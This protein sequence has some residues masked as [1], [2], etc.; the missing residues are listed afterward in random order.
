MARKYYKRNFVDAVEI[1]T[2]DLYLEDDLALS[3]V[4][5]KATDQLINS[6]VISAAKIQETLKIS[7]SALTGSNLFSSIDNINGFSQFFLTKN[8]LTNVTPES[9]Q[10]KILTPLGQKLSSFQSSSDFGDYVSG[11]F[12]PKIY[13]NNT[14]IKTD[15][16]SYFGST[17]LAT[18]EYIINNLGWLYFLNTS[19]PAGGSLAP[20]TL[21][22]S[23]LV[24]TIYNDRDYKLNDAVKDY[25]TYIW[26]NYS[27]SSV[28]FELIPNRFAIG[29]GTFTSGT[30]NLEKLKTLVD[31]V[32]SPLGIDKTD[33]KIEE[34]FNHYLSATEVV[35]TTEYRGPFS[36]FLRGVSYGMFDVNDQVEGLSNLNSIEN[37]PASHL[38]FLADILGWK[39]YGKNSASWRNQIRNAP[40]IYSKKGTKQAIIDALNAIIPQNPINTSGAI[41]E[42]YESYLPNLIYYVLATGTELFDPTTFTQDIALAHGL[43]TYSQTNK[44]FNIR[45]GVDSVLKQLITHFPDNFVVRNQPFRVTRLVNGKAW[46][47]PIIEIA[48]DVWVTAIYGEQGEILYDPRVAVDVD[49]LQDPRF[50]FNYRN[51]TTPMPPWEEE[52]F[53]DNCVVNTELLLFLSQILKTFGVSDDLVEAL[54]SYVDGYVVRASYQTD[55]YIGN[56][57]VFYTSGQHYPPN[58]GSIFANYEDDKYEYLSLW[59]GKSSTFDFSVSGGSFDDDVFQDSSAAVT[60]TDILNSLQVVDDLSPAKAIPR[61]R[62]S[63]GAAESASGAD[64]ICASV[65]VGLESRDPSGNIGG[66]TISGVYD[67]AQHGSLGSELLPDFVEDLSRTRFSHGGRPVF[68]REQANYRIGQSLMDTSNVFNTEKL[69]PVASSVGRNSARRRNFHNAL[70]K[71]KWFS[72]GGSNMPCFYNNTGTLLDFVSLGF[73]PSAFSFATPS[74]ETL[75][76]V[77]TTDCSANIANST[78]T[79]FGV[80]TKNTFLARSAPGGAVEYGSC[81]M[82]VRRDRIPEEILLLYTLNEKKKKA[83]AKHIYDLNYAY[84]SP[85]AGWVNMVDSFANKLTDEGLS[86]FSSPVF[87]QRSL[88]TKGLTSLYNTYC[89]YFSGTDN[90]ALPESISKDYVN[91]GANILSHTYGPTLRNATFVYDGSSLQ[92][93]AQLVNNT[94]V[95]PFVINLALSSSTAATIGL[96]TVDSESALNFET[97]EYRSKNIL[98]GIDF[99]DTSTTLPNPTNEFVIFD[100]NNR[101]SR[102]TSYLENNRTVLLRSRSHGLPRLRWGLRSNDEKNIL[103]PESEYELDVNY[104]TG[105]DASPVFGGGS[106]GVMIHTKKETT[107]DGSGV[108]FVW[109]KENKWE[110]VYIENLQK[111]GAKSLILAKYVHFFSDSTNQEDNVLSE[112]GDDETLLGLQAV[113]EESFSTAKL[114]FHTKNHLTLPPAPYGTNFIAS[115]SSVFNGRNVQVH[116]GYP[117]NG[118]KTQNYFVNIMQH[119]G[120]NYLSD[121]F[122]LVDSISLVNKTL[123]ESAGMP[124]SAQIP[125]SSQ[126]QK[127]FGRVTVLRSDG[128]ELMPLDIFDDDGNTISDFASTPNLIRNSAQATVFPAGFYRTTY[129]PE[130]FR[131][132]MLPA[133]FATHGGLMMKRSYPY[134]GVTNEWF[135]NG[136]KGYPWFA[137]DANG[138][139]SLDPTQY[140]MGLMHYFRDRSA[141]PSIGQSGGLGVRPSSNP[142]NTEGYATLGSVNRWCDSIFDDDQI[143]NGNQFGPLR[144]DALEDKLGLLHPIRPANARLGTTNIDTYLTLS[145]PDQLKNPLGYSIAQDKNYPS[146]GMN[147]TLLPIGS[148]TQMLFYSRR[149][150]DAFGPEVHQEDRFLDIIENPLGKIDMSTYINNF[151]K[152]KLQ[153]IL[154][155]NN[156]NNNLTLEQFNSAYPSLNRTFDFNRHRPCPGFLYQDIPTA[157]LRNET[158]YSFTI[159]IAKPQTIFQMNSTV[160]NNSQFLDHATSAM[161]TLAPVDSSSSYVRLN[162]NLET[163]ASSIQKG[164]EATGLA[165][166]IAATCDKTTSYV[167]GDTLTWYRLKVTIPYSTTE[168]SDT[169]ELDNNLWDQAFNTAR[170]QFN[171]G[172]RCSVFA[173]NGAYDNTLNSNGNSYTIGPDSVGFDLAARVLLWGGSLVEGSEPAEWSRKTGDFEVG[174]T[175]LPLF[176]Y[177]ASGNYIANDGTQGGDPSITSRRIF[178]DDDGELSY[179]SEETNKLEKLTIAYPSP[180][181]NYMQTTLITQPKLLDNKGIVHKGAIYYDGGKR[182]ER[183]DVY[184][185][186]GEEVNAYNG[187]VVDGGGTGTFIT[188]LIESKLELEPKELLH[189]FRYFNS[190][191]QKKRGEAFL[192]RV[193]SDSSEIHSVSGGSRV[194]YRTHPDNTFVGTSGST[195]GNFTN[196]NVSG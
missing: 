47:G 134:A 32:Y 79:R 116:R 98:S 180:D 67:R 152:L 176:Y 102:Q 128:E 173:Y 169:Y 58:Q 166:S 184:L 175:T 150:H 40:S 59:S 117:N 120:S 56:S 74:T 53:Y 9:F 20:S 51:K 22:A 10:E 122:L 94:L 21:V 187:L 7:A 64:Y 96:N 84:L 119:P 26:E 12:L 5:V 110:M 146:D 179:V 170:R 133:W 49:I 101:S 137:V 73:N 139:P 82:Y 18:T 99:I 158:N 63:K 68:R 195:Y 81:D 33:K 108:C 23:S 112:G 41:N 48:D 86:K 16:S 126:S 37:C 132:I 105:K 28:P 62:F 100:L 61:I 114:K 87:T 148:P 145:R 8:N 52:K 107:K 71:K 80:P 54:Y 188:R 60:T 185:S 181:N 138:N 118:N 142:T 130:Y 69:V 171:D 35:E 17:Q 167:G 88:G 135:T 6:H 147:D 97:A 36:K 123:K 174:D 196:I 38:P 46:F 178:Q 55:L 24:R 91:G 121:D 144:I 143:L 136:Y 31:V 29:A 90:N 168:K 93:S 191:G 190:V 57:F 186:E 75:S 72:R 189:L 39:L 160:N 183:G 78:D 30:Q 194:S 3:G 111:P 163:E 115:V 109:N 14:N 43:D 165:D 50:T 182:L 103:I 149:Y 129:I 76:G 4:Q 131:E 113:K 85:S 156:V 151:P 177:E 34:A 104:L 65:R 44:D 155:I 141:S 162:L 164:G 70:G 66:A 92:T 19:A 83:I 1:I 157:R 161:I 125:D 89:T 77:Y 192:T 154:A 193:P 25:Q 45:L 127:A 124:Y 13:L 159:Y 15:T 2:P 95:D 172:L 106:M 42:L 27:S 140:R 153:D 11:T